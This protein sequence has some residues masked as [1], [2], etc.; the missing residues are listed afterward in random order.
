MSKRAKRIDCFDVKGLKMDIW[1][2][3]LGYFAGICTAIV[4]LPQSIHT[5]KTKDV[6][7]LVLS[8]YIIFNV[9]M[10]SWILYGIY[11]KSA[12]M[13]IFNSISLVFASIILCMIIQDKIK[14]KK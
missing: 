5:V 4:F 14:K 13:I 1:G 11:L 7:G 6:R 12:Q 2:E 9:G 10:L 8:T 3:I